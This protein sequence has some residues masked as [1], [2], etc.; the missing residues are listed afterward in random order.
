MGMPIDL[1]IIKPGDKKKVYGQLSSSLSAIEPP[2][3]A[4]LIAAYVRQQ[5]YSVRIIDVEADNLSPE[6][7][8]ARTLEYAPVLVSFIVTGSNL[9]A[10][11][12]HMTGA[13]EYIAAF[14]KK[15][16]DVKTLL[17]GLHPSALPEK[18]LKEEQVDFVA[19]GEGF[20]TIAELLKTLKADPKT[21]RYDIAGL[22]YINDRRIYS[23]CRAPL[24]SNLDD[25]P[26]PAWDMLPME[27]YRAHNWQCFHNLG[28]RQPYGVI[29]TSFGCPFNC[30]FCNLK[31]LFGKPSIR[32]R[33]PQKVIEDI[34][35]LVK[36]YSVKNIKVL[37][38]CFVL[39]KRHVTDI[40]NLIIVRGYDLNMWAYARIDTV[41]RELLKKLKQAGFHW[42][43]YG[44]ESGNQ[45]VR[46]DAAKRG[47]GQEDI[48]RAIQITKEEGVNILGNFMFGLPEDNLETM[49]QTLDLAKELN[50]EYTNFY[51]TM[52]YPGSELYENAIKNN[53]RLPETWRGY[54]AFSEECIPLSTNYISAED[55][56]RFRDNAFVEF[57]SNPGYLK[58]IEEKFGEETVGHIKY[59]LSHKIE[60]K[61]LK[62]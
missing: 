56:L 43:C 36:E 33:S 17:W 49:Q 48:K 28:A 59:M 27:K 10:S 4:T 32:Y 40:C 2:L 58:M 42:L 41:N 35:I 20:S 6:D 8:A 60:R 53:V 21:D 3:W 57:H 47:F 38:E 23:N 39:N 50:C 18:T 54:G 52:A 34:D 37:D 51:A 9:S 44:I 46:S 45:D 22:W 62:K 26:A 29:Y 61:L 12:W 7:A 30:S 31:A 55:V 5:G 25:L 1:L 14:K 11:T 19:Q 16:P 13:R 15:S 24:I